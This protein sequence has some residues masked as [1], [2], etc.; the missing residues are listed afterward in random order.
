VGS[1]PTLDGNGVKAMTGRLK[2]TQSWFI[3]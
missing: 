2:Y 1:N 3:Q